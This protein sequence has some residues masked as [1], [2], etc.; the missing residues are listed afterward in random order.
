MV[1]RQKDPSPKVR[2]TRQESVPVPNQQHRESHSL[3]PRFL[4]LLDDENSPARKLFN[5]GVDRSVNLNFE[6][7]LLNT[8]CSKIVLH[9]K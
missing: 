9:Q 3:K 5:V 8:F 6:Q 7:L 2:R 1:K 4:S